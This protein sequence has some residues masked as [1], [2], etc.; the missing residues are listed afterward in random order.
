[1]KKLNTT[2]SF[3]EIDFTKFWRFFPLTRPRKEVIKLFLFSL[4]P[5]LFTRLSVYINWENAKV[6]K[7][8]TDKL[9]SIEFWK[10]LIKN[11]YYL[12]YQKL[13]QLNNNH[14][15]TNKIAIVIHV[16]YEDVFMEIIERIQKLENSNFKLYI[17]CPQA[18]VDFVKD[19]VTTNGFPSYI[20][21]VIN[22]GRDVLP[23]LKII[24]KVFEEGHELILKIHT[25]RSNHLHKKEIWK[26]DLFEKLLGSKSLTNAVDVFNSHPNI[27]IIGPAYHILP[28]S[29]YYGSNARRVERISKKMGVKRDQLADYHFVAGTMFFVRKSVIQP[30]LD[31]GFSEDDFE[32]ED[33]QLDGTLPHA[34]E[35]AFT[36]GLLVSGLRLADTSSTPGNI[37]CNI[38][39]NYTFAL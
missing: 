27:G 15:Q 39:M 4:F 24:P 36:C 10:R 5:S 14:K 30:I 1:L 12:N 8:K 38:K 33:G 34:L 25:K 13:D 18:K 6:Y 20:M 2:N 9:F 28:M 32:I 23:F 7:S 3:I 21:P 17:T 22:R 37:Y 31:L 19:T 11:T 16:Y 35:R 29:Y 26:N